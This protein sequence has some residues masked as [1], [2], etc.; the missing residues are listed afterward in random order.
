MLKP[1]DAQ[2]SEAPCV[3]T[4]PAL[5]LRSISVTGSTMF[6]IFA[7]PLTIANCRIRVEHVESSHPRGNASRVRVDSMTMYPMSTLNVTVLCPPG[8]TPENPTTLHESVYRAGTS[9]SPAATL[10]L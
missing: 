2:R 4:D 8:P 9:S 5:Q 3:P 7:S 10:L 6:A 1:R